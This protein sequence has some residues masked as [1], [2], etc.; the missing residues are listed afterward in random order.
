M[1]FSKIYL[2][3]HL[4][5]EIEARADTKGDLARLHGIAQRIA[6]GILLRDRMEI[7]LGVEV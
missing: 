1:S 4:R 6:W 2:G 7:D 5:I 3:A